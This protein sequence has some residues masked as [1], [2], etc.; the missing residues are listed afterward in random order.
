MTITDGLDLVEDVKAESARLIALLH[1]HGIDWRPPA[2]SL[3][4]ASRTELSRRSADEK[5]A[6]F[7]RLFRGR[8]DV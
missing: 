8:T 1:A 5:I 7:R 2:E 3:L 6:L 4:A